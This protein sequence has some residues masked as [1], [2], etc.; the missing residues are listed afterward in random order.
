[1]SGHGQVQDVGSRGCGVGSGDKR[2]C[3]DA[4]A[5]IVGVILIRQA[6]VCEDAELRFDQ[7]EPGDFGGRPHGLDSELPRRRIVDLAQVVQNHEEPLSRMCA[8]S[9]LFGPSEELPPER[10]HAIDRYSYRTVRKKESD[11]GSS[12]CVSSSL[13]IPACFLRGPGAK[14]D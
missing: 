7:I 5:R 6:D 3:G 13:V 14:P 4:P 2:R 10:S 12:Q 9:V 11:D 8:Y 1:M